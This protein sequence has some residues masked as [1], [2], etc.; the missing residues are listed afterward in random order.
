[1]DS[2]ERT[3]AKTTPIPSREK[4]IPIRRSDLIERLCDTFALSVDEREAFRRFGELL[5]ATFAHEYHVELQKLKDD[6]APFDPDADTH[7]RA[8]PP[9]AE[10]DRLLDGL[11]GRLTWLLERANFRRLTR[12]DIEA[13]MQEASHWG[14]NLK[15]DFDIFDRLEVFSRGE[16]SKKRR[17]PRRLFGLRKGLQVDV[18]TYDR[19]VV[20]LRIHADKHLPRG[21]DTNSVHVKLFKD[22][23][24]LDLEML[25]PGTRV[26]M[27]LWD[28]FKLGFSLSTGI[29]MTGYK[30]AGPVL[31]LI[32]GATSATALLGIAGGA[33]GYGVRSF[34][35]YLQTKQKYLLTLAQS[36]YF[37]NLDNNAGVLFRLLDEAEEQEARETILSYF[38][39][40][41]EAGETGWT[42]AELDARAESW[43]KQKLDV[44]V[45]FESDDA[46]AKLRR[47][48]LLTSAAD[49]GVSAKSRLRAAPLDQAMRSLD[50]AWD[51][52]FGYAN[53][54]RSKLKRAAKEGNKD[55]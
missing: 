10:Q 22:I 18:P 31:G 16:G 41:R 52:L 11:V 43:I 26:S 37:L 35:G 34:Y 38:L 9:K 40:L 25:L 42:E 50:Q 8:R 6:Y 24:K 53:D 39:L 23:P 4:F 36:L 5:S 28:R 20:L 29:G 21:V 45:D 27:S 13:A 15:V 19:L 12:A 33:V 46:I 14:V 44:D 7:R 2:E 17:T 47:L 51:E 49:G 48:S 54:E 30:L 3:F 1:M 32:A 55:Q